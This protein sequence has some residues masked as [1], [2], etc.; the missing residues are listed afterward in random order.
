MLAQCRRGA[1]QHRPRTFEQRPKP[2]ISH[3]KTAR[4][5]KTGGP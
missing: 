1:V 2:F 3:Q 4:N 5:M